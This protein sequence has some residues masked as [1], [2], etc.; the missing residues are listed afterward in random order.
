MSYCLFNLGSAHALFLLR[1][2]TPQ[3]QVIS[4]G[5]PRLKDRQIAF[6]DD[7]SSTLSFMFSSVELKMY[8]Q[9][10]IEKALMLAEEGMEEQICVNTSLE[11][12]N[13]LYYV[14]KSTESL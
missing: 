2:I 3:L 5:D 1:G 12:P 6:S 7:T 11:F 14:Q 13:S 10:G 9:T 8:P 4:K